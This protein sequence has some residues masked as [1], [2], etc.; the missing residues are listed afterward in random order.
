MRCLLRELGPCGEEAPHR[1]LAPVA[2]SH[3][4]GEEVFS[5]RSAST[6]RRE[7]PAR[8]SRSLSRTLLALGRSSRGQLQGAGAG[9]CCAIHHH[10]GSDCPCSSANGPSRGGVFSKARRSRTMRKCSRFSR[11]TPAGSR[12]AR[13]AVRWSSEF[14]CAWLKTNSSSSF[15]TRIL[16]EGSDTDIAVSVI[17]ETQALHRDLR[18]CSFDRGFHSP[19]N[20]AQLDAMLDLNAL[21][22]KGR[23]SVAER[24]RE[25]AQAFAEARAPAPGGRVGNQQP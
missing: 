24:E 25:Q 23:L 13:L 19:G 14:R 22:R 4:R 8:P 11:N 2:T 15:T 3:A 20:R 17:N 5:T 10:S 12:R 6:R 9:R 7:E 16:W 18:V 21:P 1:T